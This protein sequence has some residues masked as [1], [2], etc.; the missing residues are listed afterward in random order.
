MLRGFWIPLV[1]VA[2]VAAG[3]WH[4]HPRESAKAIVA[5]EWANMQT[6]PTKARLYIDGRDKPT[7]P[8]PMAPPGPAIDDTPSPTVDATLLPGPSSWP[9]LNPKAS[10]HK[11]WLLAE[12]PY[13][14]PGDNRH[15]ITFTFD[16][17]PFPETTPNV[18]RILAKHHVRATFFLIGRYLDGDDPHAEHSRATAREIVKEGHLVGNHSHDHVLLTTANE[19]ERLEKI[20]DGER[21]IERAIGSRPAFFRPPYGQVDS[22]ISRYLAVHD[23]ELTLWSIEVSDMKNDDAHLMATSLEEQI[24]HDGDGIVLLHDIRPATADALAI[25]LDWLKLHR[26]NPEH[27]EVVGYD[28]VD[29][30]EYLRRI[31]ASPQPFT[32]RRDV[33]HARAQAWAG[34]GRREP[35]P[36]VEM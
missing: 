5:S 17:G 35:R 36:L 26:Y 6:W 4:A 1:F 7:I 19:S 33:E 13:H 18:L 30:A 15:A 20:E 9:R 32:D 27:P 28:V 21:S 2:S 34:A 10:V 29:L 22:D 31:A 23:T 8:P 12:G 3:E 11:A 25:V 16:D 24:E 14:A